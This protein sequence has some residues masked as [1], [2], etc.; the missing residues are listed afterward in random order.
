M[1]Q[2][3][4]SKDSPH[5]QEVD[6]TTLNIHQLTTLQQQLDQEIN[7]FQE[8]MQS[9][10]LA[11]RKFQISA[12]CLDKVTPESE[13]RQVL[14]PLT[15]SMYVPGKMID[16][17]NVIIDIGTRY[18]AEKDTDS[19]KDYFHRKVKF[20]TEQMEKIQVLGYEKSRIRDAITEVMKMKIQSQ[21]AAS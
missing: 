12:E 2:I 1:S 10:K 13:G 15:G 16:T 3:S 6:L 7:L 11:Q 4:S 20:V 8:S 17:K 21:P 14:V 19:A 5:M 9:L 18:Y